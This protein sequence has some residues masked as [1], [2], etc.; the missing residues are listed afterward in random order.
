MRKTWYL[1]QKMYASHQDSRGKIQNPKFRVQGW[2]VCLLFI[3]TNA[4]ILR[5]TK[6][7]IQ[8]RGAV[9]V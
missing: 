5:G 9:L 7:Y 8:A 6:H 4:A 1:H 3:G 2:C